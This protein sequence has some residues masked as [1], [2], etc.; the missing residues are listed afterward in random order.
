MELPRVLGLTGSIGTGKSTV[1]KM[2]RRLRIP[3]IDAD[4]IVHQLYEA[5]P[6]LIKKVRAYQDSLIHKGKVDRHALS[7]LV[8]KEPSFLAHLEDIVHP[9]VKQ[10]LL[11]AIEAAK[12]EKVPLVVLE[13]PLLFEVKFDSL[14]HFTLVVHA[15]QAL[16]KERVLNRPDMTE[17]KLLKILARQ[18]P[19]Q[20]KIN[21]A[22]FT[23]DTSRPRVHIFKELL[24]HLER[25]CSSHA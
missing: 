23:L 13:V 24:K 25:I 9:L 1:A 16:Q 4:K 3:V 19:Q 22:D 5:S 18:L 6:V 2:F 15:P 10:A 12:K 7:Q 21:C 14:C 8:I 17:E 11:E 20:E